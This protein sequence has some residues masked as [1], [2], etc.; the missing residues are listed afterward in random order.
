MY[1]FGFEAEF[2]ERSPGVWG[3]QDLI[4]CAIESADHGLR[5]ADWSNDAE[6]GSVGKIRIACFNKCWNTS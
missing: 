2:R 1:R 6:Q 5:C 3:I 4:D